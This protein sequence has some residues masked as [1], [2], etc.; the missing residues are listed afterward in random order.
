MGDAENA[1][2]CGRLLGRTDWFNICYST[3]IT[4][5]ARLCIRLRDVFMEVSML[6]NLLNEVDAATSGPSCP[7]IG[8]TPTP[9]VN[10]CLIARI[11]WCHR[12]AME[13]RT[14]LEVEEWY[15]EQKGLIDALLERDCTPEYQG[16]PALQERYRR[17][18]QDGR[19][20]IQVAKIRPSCHHTYTHN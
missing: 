10:A 13:A 1:R 8:S 14:T 12:Q 2:N 11:G 16:T 4:K 5:T 6:P 19:V 18:L 17:G 7:S 9:E 15:S 20:L 3:C